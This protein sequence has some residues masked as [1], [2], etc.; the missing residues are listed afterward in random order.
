MNI[1]QS[2]LNQLHSLIFNTPKKEKNKF[3]TRNELSKQTKIIFAYQYHLL[4]GNTS[5]I[6]FLKRSQAPTEIKLFSHFAIENN[7]LKNLLPDLY[8]EFKTSTPKKQIEI[9][10]AKRLNLKDIIKA[11]NHQNWLEPF[12]ENE[13][14]A[15]SAHKHPQI[16]S[17]I[18]PNGSKITFDK[19]NATKVKMAIIDQGIFPARCIVEGAYGPVA[20]NQFAQYIKQ[21]KNGGKI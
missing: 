11:Y 21:V 9:E 16:S 17:F 15:V 19:E 5:F 2:S 1:T 13:I 7:M 18:T 8:Y 4:F 10:Y 3:N 12:N 6:E 14:F 20:K